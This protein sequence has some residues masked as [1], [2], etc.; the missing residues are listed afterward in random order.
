[1]TPYYDKDG[2]TIYHGDCRD[3]LPHIRGVTGIVTDPPAGISFM[4]KDWDG[5][6]GGRDAW[7][8]WM[9]DIAAKAIETLPPGGIALVWAIPRTSHWT[10]TAWENAG[11]ECRDVITHHFGSGFPKSL[12]ISKAIDKVA[13]AE[14]KEIGRKK[15]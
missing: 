9:T 14:R 15:K 4:G 8:E 12:D 6:K 5:H 10:A 3:A 7:I 1:M 11:W 13:G 2:I